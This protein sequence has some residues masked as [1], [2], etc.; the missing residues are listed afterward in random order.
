M[1]TEKFQRKPFLV[2]AIQV[3]EE[4]MEEVA[5]WCKGTITHT[6]PAIAEQLKKP[7]QTW[8]QVE[9]QQP[10]N[11]RQKQAFVGDWLLY[12]N[13][14]FKIYAPKAFERTFDPVFKEE[15]EIKIHVDEKKPSPKDVA[16]QVK[17][18]RSA[19]TGE[20]VSDEV[21]AEN[22]DTTVSETIKVQQKGTNNVVTVTREELE[23]NGIVLAEDKPLTA[24]EK[25][26]AQRAQS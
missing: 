2:D 25:I 7:V 8:I 5:K 20:F 18:N 26:Q 24:K 4:N 22:P 23:A 10:M 12:A 19:V 21:A 9:T 13:R 11:D 6:D 1:K 3:T 14:G 16:E 17:V 15:R